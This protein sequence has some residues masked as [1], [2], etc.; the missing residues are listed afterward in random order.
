MKWYVFEL[1]QLFYE[2]DYNGGVVIIDFCGEVVVGLFCDEEGILVVDVD[3][4]FVWVCKVVSDLVGYY[5]WF[6]FF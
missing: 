3:F 6:D 2:F 5:L 4:V 1:Y